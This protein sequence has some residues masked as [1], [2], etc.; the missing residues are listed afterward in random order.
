MHKITNAHSERTLQTRNN[1][2]LLIVTFIFTAF[3]APVAT[4]APG[5]NMIIPRKE[6]STSVESTP[7]SIFPHWIHRARY[8]CD[9]CHDDLFKMELGA[10][11]ISKALMKK[12]QSCAVCH[13]GE[14]A[15]GV[16]FSTCH[17]CHATVNE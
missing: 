15:F 8:R 16:G 10:T 3:L 1:I 13:N 9:A 7:A 14:T 6:G 2:F 17:L 5:D 11:E 4:S 12:K